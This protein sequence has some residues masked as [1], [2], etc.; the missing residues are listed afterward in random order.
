MK[1]ENQHNRKRR[2]HDDDDHQAHPLAHDESNWLVSY[3]DMMTLLFGFFVLLYS[4]SKVDHNQFDVVRKE[5]IKYFGGSLKEN[6]GAVRIKK[7]LEDTIRKSGGLVPVDKSTLNPGLAASGLGDKDFEVKIDDFGVTLKFQSNMLFDPGHAQ[8]R[9]EFITTLNKIGADLKQMPI[10]NIEVEGHTDDDPINS[11]QF[12]SN[13]ELSSARA[14]AVANTL[15]QS[16][17]E[18][19]KFR[20]TGYAAGHPEKPHKNPDGTSNLENKK[21]NRRVIIKVNLTNE[22]PKMMRQLARKGFQV[23]INEQNSTQTQVDFKNS[24][25]TPVSKPTQI[26]NQPS[27][28]IK[29]ESPQIKKIKEDLKTQEE[30]LKAA[31]EKLKKVKEAEKEIQEFKK[32]QKKSEDLSKKIQ[33]INQQTIETLGKNVNGVNNEINKTEKPVE[34]KK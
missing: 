14:S 29:N 15:Q 3:A 26:D 34:N 24:N 16:G 31:Q 27:S 20:V 6:P 7:E 17:I 25:S 28:E 12:P 11:T 4:F 32:M 18:E 13:W 10:E 19:S 5:M 1:A 21:L 9:P 33:L 8:L 23:S 2:I 30:E 22:A